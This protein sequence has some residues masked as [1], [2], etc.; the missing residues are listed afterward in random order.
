MPSPRTVVLLAKAF[1]QVVRSRRTGRRHPRW[2]LFFETLRLALRN[3]ASWT[4]SLDWKGQR[5]AWDSLA[6]P[7][8]FFRHTRIEALVANGVPCESFGPHAA[9]SSR[10]LL[11][12]HGGSYIYG[13]TTSHRELLVNLA[14]ACGAKVFAP[15]YRLAPEHPFPAALEDAVTVYRWLLDQGVSPKNVVIAGDS[16]GAGLSVATLLSLRDQQYALPAAA[17]LLCPWVNLAERGASWDSNACYDWTDPAQFDLWVAAYAGEKNASSPLV[18]P[19][20]A[21]LRGLPPLLIQLG[22]LEMVFDQAMAFAEQA[23]S[24][25]VPTTLHVYD[26]MIHVWQTFGAVCPEAGLAIQEIAAFVRNQTA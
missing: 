17:A 16:A 25:G 21:D 12:L 10:V 1:P 6:L 7:K 24:A 9:P 26:D 2:S 18:S 23:K 5:E 4:H 20:L 13:S 15:N 14:E 11:Y 22:G 3:Y 19:A 8:A